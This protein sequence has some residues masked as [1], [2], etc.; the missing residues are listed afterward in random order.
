MPISSDV[1]VAANGNI[2]YT[3]AAHGVSGAGYY[4]VIELHR[5]L[6]DLADNA[7]T[8]GDDILDITDLTPSERSTDNIITLLNSYNIDDTLAEHLYDGSIIQA[9]GD[10]IYDGL[11]VI[12]TEGM[13]LQIVQN[14]AVISNSFWNTIP[15]GGTKKG[16]N[17]DVANGI[18]HRFLVKVRNAG[19]DI[20]SRKLLGQTR[21]L[22]FT[23]SEFRINGTSR[24]NNVMALSYAS[25][26]NNQTSAATLAGFSD[27]VN[28]TSGYN[29][30]DVNNDTV[31]EGYY[32]KW[33]RGSRTINQFYERLK[34]L[35]R[36]G[37]SSSLYGLNG[38]L[39]R[40]ITHEINTD[41]PT[42]TFSAFEP[43][44]WST[45]TGQM[46]AVNSTTNPTKMWIQLLTGTAPVDNQSI[47]GGSSAASC[48]VNVT[49]TERPLSFPFCGV[50]TGSALIGSYGLGLEATDLT[51][52]DRLFDLTN[53]QRVAPNYVTFSV[54][55]LVSGED[56]VLV[57][58][59]SGGTLQ[60]NQFTLSGG[61][62]SGATTITVNATIPSDTPSTGT[63]RV[64][65]G[66]TYVRVTYTGYS[67]AQFT[68]CSGAPTA[69]NGAAVF[70]S[71]ID[72]LASGSTASF[73][74]VYASD[75][76][77]FVRIRDG[78]A[79][80]IKTFETTA[81]LGSAGGSSTAIRT[82]DS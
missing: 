53:T 63:I 44:S 55:G 39:F 43:V 82:S 22:G 18:S 79:S 36:T 7:S 74:S 25:D 47:T 3:G 81:T 52:N 61:I 4:S 60:T 16:L 9:N 45:G 30:I 58:P 35:T 10:T 13:D 70:I 46:L 57:G 33:D 73:T 75:R 40:G 66:N 26:L 23:F 78:G 11:V 72:T 48:L 27:V 19:A 34:W 65:D 80:P 41:T 68:G 37:T 69:S 50:S 29:L 8:A 67:G 59:G 49:V 21:E 15:F 28:V 62:S 76:S 1:S 51:A 77:L 12:A 24:G 56:R 38:S 42:G 5:L 17:R 2:R 54:G 32:S 31:G 64:F 20:D 14:G 71:Y 6:Q